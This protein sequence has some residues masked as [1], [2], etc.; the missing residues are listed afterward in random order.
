MKTKVLLLCALALCLSFSTGAFA[1]VEEGTFNLS[2][3][4]GGIFP[5]NDVH[6]DNG[7]VWGVG[8]GYNFTKNW[9][10]EAFFH[11]APDLDI[12]ITPDPGDP[13]IGDGKISLGRLNALYHFDTNTAFVPYLTLG[14]GA[15]KSSVDL[16]PPYSNDADFDDSY[17]SFAANGGV[18]F[19]YFFNEH[20]ALRLEASYVHGFKKEVFGPP[21]TADAAPK[22]TRVNAALVTA[23][24][25]FQFGGAQPACIDSDFDGVCDNLDQCPGTPAGYRVDPANGCPITVSIQ[26]DVKFDFDKSVVKPQYRGEVEKA[27]VFLN[28]HPGSSVVVEGHTDSK[29]SDEYN[30][31]LSE[32]RAAAVRDYL[33]KE[34]SGAASRVSAVGY[35]ESNPIATNDTEAGRALNRRVVGVFSGT[36][37]AN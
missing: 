7:P 25:T 31:K 30:K 16:N 32:R 24:L 6:L 3:M 4:G 22:S 17:N 27:A 9:G 26:L 37:V 10:L 1:Q 2:F 23:G 14:I 18:G 5:D 19:K 11:Y 36:D 28:Q 29:G 21:E 33:V 8:L 13:P 34:F 20:V 35:G 12:D 15:V